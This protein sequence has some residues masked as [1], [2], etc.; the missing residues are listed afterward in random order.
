MKWLFCAAVAALP[1]AGLAQAVEQSQPT[2]AEGEQA[3][4]DPCLDQRDAAS[5]AGEQKKPGLVEDAGGAAANTGGAIAGGAVAGPIGAAV[6]GVVVDHVGRAIKKVVG[7]GKRK[8]RKA[9]E[10]ALVQ[11]CQQQTAS[12][13]QDQPAPQATAAAAADAGATAARP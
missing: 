2:L 10:E 13:A 9:D 1:A 5:G 11:A 7:G 6:G 8:H 4:V 3:R 12:A